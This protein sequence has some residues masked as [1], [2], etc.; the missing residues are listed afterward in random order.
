MDQHRT[1]GKDGR[2]HRSFEVTIDSSAYDAFWA[3]VETSEVTYE[4]SWPR[5]TDT[6]ALRIVSAGKADAVSLACS[7]MSDLCPECDLRGAHKGTCSQSLMRSGGPWGLNR[8][9]LTG[10]VSE[11][12][13]VDESQVK[14]IISAECCHI[15]RDKIRAFYAEGGLKVTIP[16]KKSGSGILPSFLHRH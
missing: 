16:G 4:L 3:W 1:Q 7:K 9:D 8:L 13:E 11:C 15:C 5:D 2:W 12:T 14:R 10:A 6:Y